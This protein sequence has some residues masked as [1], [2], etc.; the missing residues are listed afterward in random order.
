MII[1]DYEPA[2]GDDVEVTVKG[3]VE[4]VRGNGKCVIVRLA[5]DTV[6]YL[7]RFADLLVAGA[8][9]YRQAVAPRWQAGDVVAQGD[10]TYQR[11]NRGVWT[12]SNAVFA[13]A[14]DTLISRL[15]DEHGARLVMRDGE[16]SP[17]FSFAG[18]SR[19]VA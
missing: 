19:G 15:V 8:V 12:S 7:P 6:V 18:E 2:V 11:D 3:R 9:I 14:D 13:R 1:H 4:S 17:A 10:H 16:P 5:P